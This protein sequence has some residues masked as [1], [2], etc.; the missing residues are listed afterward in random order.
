MQPRPGV[1]KPALQ[2]GSGQMDVLMEYWWA[3]AAVVV[4]LIILALGM[5]VYRRWLRS[6]ACFVRMEAQCSGAEA[7]LEKEDERR[8]SLLNL[9]DREGRDID[10]LKQRHNIDVREQ[11]L[12]QAQADLAEVNHRISLLQKTVRQTERHMRKSGRYARAE[13]VT[14][15]HDEQALDTLDQAFETPG[16][17]QEL[18]ASQPHS[19]RVNENEP[20]T[21]PIPVL[22]R[23]VQ[24]TPHGGST[25]Y[26]AQDV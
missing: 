16:S 21:T 9:I 8:A 4:V 17:L 25:S 11:A 5:I 20:P 1:K 24:A 22:N 15:A 12:A 14:L 19:Q 3:I 23:P 18:G 6:D 13:Q 2:T 10:A 26:N 7:A